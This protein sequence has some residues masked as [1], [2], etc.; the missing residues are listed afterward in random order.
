[1]VDFA[2][3][4]LKTP[5]EVQHTNGGVTFCFVFID[6]PENLYSYIISTQEFLPVMILSGD[7]VYMAKS[8]IKAFRTFDPKKLE[9]GYVWSFD[10]YIVLGVD[11]DISLDDLHNHYIALLKNVHPD[12]ISDKNLH[13]VFKDLASD[14]TR[15]IISAY[16]FIRAEK[17]SKGYHHE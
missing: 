8:D 6:S 3:G 13:S 17:L 14:V 9:K 4:K 12:I 5:I 2:T 10:P 15:R 16:E 1:M 7:I 11:D